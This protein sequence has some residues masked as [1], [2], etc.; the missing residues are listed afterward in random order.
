MKTKQKI[1]PRNPVVRALMARTGG[2][3]GRHGKSGKAERRAA[4][5]NLRKEI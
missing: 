2:S 3:A 4:K 1:V 5:I